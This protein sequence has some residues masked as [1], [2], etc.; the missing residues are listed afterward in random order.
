VV[1]PD[2]RSPKVVSLLPSPLLPSLRRWLHHRHVLVVPL[3]PALHRRFE[4]RAHLISSQ[5]PLS[6]PFRDM[7]G[8]PLIP[9][10]VVPCP[11]AAR[12]CSICTSFPEG[13]KVVRE[14]LDSGDLS[15]SD[16]K[17]REASQRCWNT[18]E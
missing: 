15:V 4:G 14:K 8:S 2:E 10:L 9:R 6:R 5:H 16:P 11:T 12:A 18:Y 17:V 1:P 3:L 13:E 7:R